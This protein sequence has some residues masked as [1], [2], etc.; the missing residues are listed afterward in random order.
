MKKLIAIALL[1]L[2]AAQLHAQINISAEI[3]P[4]A[5]YR[6]GYKILNTAENDPAAFV[7]QRTRLGVLFTNNRLKTGISFQDVR[8]WGDESLTSSKGVFGDEASV[9]LNEAWIEI[10][11][12]GKSVMKIGRQYF[13]YDDARLLAIRNWNQHSVSY[14]ALLYRFKNQAMQVD[15]AFSF[16]NEKEQIFGQL[17]P[18]GKMKTLDFFR[19][20]WKNE[21]LKIAAI[22]LVSG[23]TA[24]EKSETIYLRAS[25]GLYVSCSIDEFN[26]FFSGYYQHGKNQS[27]EKVS[28]FNLNMEAS[29][30]IRNLKLAS[31]FSFLSGNNPH[32][33]SQTDHRFDLLYGARHRYYGEMDYFSNL[34]VATGNAGLVD[35]FLSLDYWFGK[36]MS[37]YA[38][39][40]YFSNQHQYY[41][42]AMQ[43]NEDCFLATEL[44]LGLSADLSREMNLKCGFAL[45]KPSSTLE[46]IQNLDASPISTWA[47]MQLTVKPS[48]SF[49]S[50][51]LEME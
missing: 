33:S 32:N 12:T 30:R 46:A 9:D 38:I 8:V 48:L 31:G 40:H 5:E 11:L 10:Q 23:H 3:R 41:H 29:Y 22:S 19:A 47:W 37:I 50:L 39:T 7:S 35:I 45:L 14:D 36:G 34:P 16:N 18:P 42:S 17:Y 21:T 26:G 24:S 44:D 6:N 13:E 49:N 1:I 20:A 15:A 28:A 2:I 25:Y 4:R 43:K 27:G 51:N